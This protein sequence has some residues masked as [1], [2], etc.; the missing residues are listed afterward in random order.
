M[1]QPF[2]VGPPW[3]QESFAANEA[4]GVSERGG[5]A[6]LDDNPDGT[7]G[8][9]PSNTVPNNS[10]ECF[11]Q[12]LRWGVDSLYLSYPGQLAENVDADLRRLKKLAQ[13]S[14]DLAA[15]AQYPIGDHIFEVKDKSTGLFPFTIEDGAFQI[16]LSAHTAKSVPMAYVKVSSHYLT[17]KTPE[18]AEKTLRAMLEALGNVDSPKVSRI[19]LFVD[20]ASSIS[21]ESW[22]R[23]AWVTKASGLSQYAQDRTFTGWLIGAGSALMARLYNKRI[24]IE[25]SGKTYLEPLWREAGWDTVQPIWRLELQFKREVLDQLALGSLSGVLNNLSGLWSYGTTQ[26][27]KLT[28]PSE[29]DKTRSRWPIH[30]LWIALSSVDWETQGGP[31]LRKYSPSRAPSKDWIGARALS[32]I[33]SFGALV[34]AKDFD[35]AFNAVGDAAF[36]SLAG[37]ADLLGLPHF[38]LFAEK[39]E[40]LCRKYNTSVNAPPPE[41]TEP[42]P[43]SREYRRQT[44]GY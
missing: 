9:P 29:T 21:M 11:F 3:S 7:K 19:D 5:A 33:A 2:D 23:D 10:N 31:L 4:A 18:H 12:S 40:L 39:V 24:E 30:P 1:T 20:F 38:Q 26:W 36:N 16:R 43:V 42:D 17:H 35:A 44:Q 41:D 6:T 25:K 27:L 13:G 8:T 32:A 37:K 22:T 34:G 14:D 15:K 28:V